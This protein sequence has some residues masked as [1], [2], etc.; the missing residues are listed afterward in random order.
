MALE[1]LNTNEDFLIKKFAEDIIVALNNE[2]LLP[3]WFVRHCLYLEYNE[4]IKLIKKDYADC[5][6]KQENKIKA[7]KSNIAK[8]TAEIE[9]LHK[10]L[11]KLEKKLK[12]NDSHIEK[13]LAKEANVLKSIF[14]LGIYSYLISQR[15]KNRFSLK[16]EK[17]NTRIGEL[18]C[19]IKAKENTINT[20]RNE[21]KNCEGILKDNETKL[22]NRKNIASIE[23]MRKVSEIK[24]LDVMVKNDETFIPLKLF[25]GY[26]YEKIIG[27]YVVHN[28]EKNKYYVGQSK[29][30]M[31]RIK[32]H[33]KGTVPQNPIFAEDYYTSNYADKQNL[34]EIKIIRC[35][36]KDELDKTEKNLI[37]Q[38]DSWSNGYNGTSGNT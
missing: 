28:K 7:A 29:D 23:H 11:I 33:F 2:E 36:T 6:I 38:Y 14:T 16:S 20:A 17:L 25:S 31:R 10:K 1:S 21:I 30:V 18:D 8:R 9:P 4:K 15:R 37:Y 22:K 12:K 5:K 3:S 24:P 26:E 27:C 13:V 19:S 35:E 32:Q 34:F